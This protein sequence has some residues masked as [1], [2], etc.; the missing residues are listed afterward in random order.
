M[1]I[2]F[3]MMRENVRALRRIHR[4]MRDRMAAIPSLKNIEQVTVTVS[5]DEF[6]KA[7]WAMGY[8]KQ[9]IPELDAEGQVIRGKGH[10][11]RING[12]FVRRDIP[13]THFLLKG[14]PVFYED[15]A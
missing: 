6:E 2:T 5:R 4:E 7:E 1:P 14:Q 9:W 13:R 11:A 15:H 8:L 3:G 10:Y 12:R